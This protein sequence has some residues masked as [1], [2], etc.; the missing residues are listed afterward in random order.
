M[1]SPW[2]PRNISDMCK[3]QQAP[4]TQCSPAG[5][6]FLALLS[7]LFGG[8]SFS[9][10]HPKNHTN[11]NYNKKLLKI[12]SHTN[13]E[14]QGAKYNYPVNFFNPNL[15]FK[16]SKNYRRT[17]PL[18]KSDYLYDFFNY[19]PPLSYSN[20]IK[21]RSQFKLEQPVNDYDFHKKDLGN[22]ESTPKEVPVTIKKYKKQA[23]RKCNKKTEKYDFIIVGAG[24][25]GCVIANRLSEIKEWKILLIEAGPE[26][27]DVT[28]APS[29]APTLKGSSI[30]WNFRT[31]PEELTCRSARGQSC[32]WT[33]GKTMGG[34]SSINFMV[35]MRGNRLD[36]DNWAMLGN[37]GWSYNEV[38][39]YFKKSENNRDTESFDNYYH[40]VGGPLNVERYSYTDINTIMLVDAFKEKGLPL[41][42]LTAADNFGTNV[43][44]STSKDG[45]RWSTNV[46]FIKPIRSKRANIHILVNAYATKIIINKKTK[47]AHG[48]KYT[49]KG[50]FY[51]AY[52]RKEVIISCGSINSP[53]LLMLSG[54]GPKEHLESLNIEVLA[55]LPVGKNLQDHVSTDAL[56]ISLSNKTSTTVTSQELLSEVKIYKN[57]YPKKFGPL[58]STSVLNSV[59]FIKTKYAN[60]QA[61]DI[62]IHFDARNVKEFYSDPTTYLAT[63]YFP[64]SFYD[65][66]A[67]R[68][69]LLTPKSRG[70]L[71]LNHTDPVFSQPLVYP[72]FFTNKDDVDILV[73]AMR[74]LVDLDNT[75]IFKNN[76]VRFVREP[77]MGC[78]ENVWGTYEYFACLLIQYTTTIYHPAGTCKMGPEWDK[79]AVV[80]PRLRV[81]GI[82]N[83]RVIDASIMPVIVRGNT[84][85]PTIMIAEKASD[86]IKEDWL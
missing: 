36:Y 61:P 44:S 29:I 70:H 54:I 11:D 58:A 72:R 32:S 81:Y 23:N 65:G 38:L 1:L 49:K 75:E 27:P 26:E 83:L 9:V 57:Q 33:S 69:I 86:I 84:N 85:A 42:D 8:V 12:T 78:R 13:P 40:A 56:I 19:H 16:H 47:L 30:D 2:T 82:K 74:F 48:I 4:L 52:A 46:A 60:D 71:F 43:A 35:Y 53:K 28:M 3:E 77:V 7:R 34:S 51:N 62:Q 39:P 73:E 76:G 15:E 80:D 79:E 10:S 18:R 59:A 24:S 37:Y 55:N 6:M 64:F 14:S 68:P 45:Q 25:A 67:A 20:N 50:K 22:Q 63:N 41:N 31:Q 21:N 5:I 66:L 17:H